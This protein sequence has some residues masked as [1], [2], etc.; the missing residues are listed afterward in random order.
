VP[1]LVDKEKRSKQR[2]SDQE[3]VKRYNPAIF[4]TFESALMIAKWFNKTDKELKGPFKKLRQTSMKEMLLAVEMQGLDDVRLNAMDVADDS[5]VTGS[6]VSDKILMTAF[7]VSIP[8]I[9]GLRLMAD[10]R[11]PIKNIAQLN[12]DMINSINEMITSASEDI[13]Q[14]QLMRGI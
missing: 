2:E 10:A 8:F 14:M 6:Y 4:P 13:Y 3:K 11:A 12:V 7:P 1:D 5:G 9:M